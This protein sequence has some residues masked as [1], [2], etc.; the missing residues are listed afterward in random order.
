[1]AKRKRKVLR[2]YQWEIIFGIE[3][4]SDGC[5]EIY[6]HLEDALFCE[7][8]TSAVLKRTYADEDRAHFSITIGPG[9][10]EKLQNLILKFCQEQK[11]SLLQGTE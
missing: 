5:Q 8:N 4:A 10:Q 3:V 6:R 7:F 1:M 2:F 11:L 9:N